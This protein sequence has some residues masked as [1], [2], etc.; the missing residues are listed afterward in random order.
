MEIE[1]AEIEKEMEFISQ[2][3]EK[4]RLLLEKKGYARMRRQHNSTTFESIKDTSSSTRYRWQTETKNMLEY[5][6]GGEDGA[7]YGAWDF[8]C[9]YTGKD[10]MEKLILYYKVKS[11]AEVKKAVATKYLSFLSRRKY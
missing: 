7:V 1:K 9:R 11:E 4:L 5:I 10:L 6:H 2:E 3:Y 8:V